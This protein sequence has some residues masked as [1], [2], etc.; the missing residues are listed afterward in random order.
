MRKL[1]KAMAVLMCLGWLMSAQALAVTVDYGR[2]GALQVQLETTSL[3]ED[4]SGLEIS[5]Y[6][7]GKMENPSG[8]LYYHVS[9]AFSDCGVSLDYQNASE[10]ETAA[11]QI[12]AYIRENS[13]LPIAVMT[14]DVEGL[15]EF[16][17][18]EAG[19]YFAHKTGGTAEIDIIPFIVTVPY[20][21]NGELL[22]TV[23]VNPKMEIR[24]TTSPT[25]TPAPTRTPGSD[26][27][28]SPTNPTS[29]EKLP[30]TGVV[31]WPVVAL[32]IGG[33]VLIALGAVFIAAGDKRR[34]P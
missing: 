18:L 5:L 4:W 10:A 29:E 19:V 13:I 32:S 8:D 14:T 2:T 24:P 23:P 28:P 34:K 25:A 22:Y 30:Q 17:G 12:E 3:R 15:A 27:T 6:R 21:K 16:A 11:R 1:C 26:Q 20:Y 7:I 31:R 33:C 9:G